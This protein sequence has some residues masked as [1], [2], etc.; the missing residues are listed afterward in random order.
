MLKQILSCIAP[1]ITDE[2]Y[3]LII[4]EQKTLY[5]MPWPNEIEAEEIIKDRVI[6]IQTNGRVRAEIINPE[7]SEE[8]NEEELKEFVVKTI[9]NFVS[10][11]NKIKKIIFIKGTIINLVI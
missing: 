10:D 9:P 1:H 6:V 2:I 8:P 3:S 4:N 5:G 7:L 11:K